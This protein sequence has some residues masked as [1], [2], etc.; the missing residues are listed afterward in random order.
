MK[1]FASFLNGNTE[2]D[3]AAT[4]LITFQKNVKFSHLLRFNDRVVK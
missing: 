3:F 4:N 2:T 1:D